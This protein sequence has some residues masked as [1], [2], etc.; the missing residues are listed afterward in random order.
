MKPKKLLLVISSLFVV[1]TL[2]GCDI[3]NL[4]NSNHSITVPSQEVK[5][6][7]SITKTKTEG[8]VDTYTITYSDKTT[9]NFTVTNGKDG[10]Q[11]IQGV[12]G[13]D[14]KTPVI[15]IGENGNWFIDGVDSNISAKGE[16][17]DTG[18]TGPQ[19]PQ[20]EKGD[21]GDTGETGSKGR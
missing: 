10:E 14:G 11:G 20:G 17:G 18:E 21:K 4:E 15:T 19:G 8:N 16:K 7:V 5:T 6:I 13:K 1:S 9:F 3:P 12:P 2:S